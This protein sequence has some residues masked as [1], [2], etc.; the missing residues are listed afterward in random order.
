M[1]MRKKKKKTTLPKCCLLKVLKGREGRW[2]KEIEIEN[3]NV[4]KDEV[5]FELSTKEERRVVEMLLL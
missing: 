4:V 2:K 5:R 1:G 3:Q